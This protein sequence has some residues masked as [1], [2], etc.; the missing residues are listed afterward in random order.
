MYGDMLLDA[1]IE[2][3]RGTEESTVVKLADEVVAVHLMAGDS[4]LI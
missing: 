1:L 4:D 3:L 2:K